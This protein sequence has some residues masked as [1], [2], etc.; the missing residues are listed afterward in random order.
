MKDGKFWSAQ[1]LALNI[2]D[3]I[4]GTDITESQVLA[5]N[6]NDLYDW[7]DI[8]GFDYSSQRGWHQYVRDVRN[9]KKHPRIEVST[10]QLSL[11][12]M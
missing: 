8:Q 12:I 2:V 11:F 3:G 5:W 1:D 10:E 4:E 6:E 9:E 7:L